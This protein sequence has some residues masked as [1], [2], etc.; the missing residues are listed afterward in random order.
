MQR[1][2]HVAESGWRCRRPT[3]PPTDVRQRRPAELGRKRR[4]DPDERVQ[5]LR[6]RRQHR[7]QPH[8]HPHFNGNSFHSNTSYNIQ[9]QS[10]AA[11]DATGNW[12]GTTDPLVITQQNDDD[13]DDLNLG[14]VASSSSLSSPPNHRPL[15]G[16]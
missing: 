16:G 6:H 8:A 5:R 12:W 1:A 13:Y 4:L 9:N 15:S 11:I 7:R 14:A 2:L 3:D 10:T